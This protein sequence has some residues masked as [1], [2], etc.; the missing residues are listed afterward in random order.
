MTPHELDPLFLAFVRRA[1][2]GQLV[3]AMQHPKAKLWHVVACQRALA[4]IECQRCQ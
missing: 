4:R 2:E 3:R 1:T